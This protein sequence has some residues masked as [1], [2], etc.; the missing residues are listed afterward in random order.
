M[1]AYMVILLAVYARP[2][3]H[4]FGVHKTGIYMTREAAERAINNAIIVQPSVSRSFYQ[5]F[6]ITMEASLDNRVIAVT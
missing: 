4:G 1:D 3:V 2:P 5:I 6:K